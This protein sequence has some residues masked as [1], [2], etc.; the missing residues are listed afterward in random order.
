[1][2]AFANAQSFVEASTYRLD[3]DPD[4][5]SWAHDGA[6]ADAI[7]LRL[8]E[9]LRS[10]PPAE[11]DIHIA[12]VPGPDGCVVSVRSAQGETT[13]LP[14]EAEPSEASLI[15]AS[16]RIA[17]LAL[18]ATGADPFAA[19][20]PEPEPEPE[21]A[22][23][24]QPPTEETTPPEPEPEPDPEAEQPPPVAPAAPAPQA[25]VAPNEPPTT[26]FG[27]SLTPG[28]HA[29]SAA[30]PSAV[31]SVSFNVVGRTAGVQGF[32]LGL[33][34]NLSD[35]DVSGAQI[36][37][38]GNHIRGALSGL[39]AA[40]FY[41]R[42]QRGGQGFQFG[43]LNHAGGSFSG[44]QAGFGNLAADISGAQLGF[45]N[46]ASEDVSGIQIGFVNLARS[47]TAS[48]GLLS[49]VRS[50]PVRVEVVGSTGGMV[51]VGIRHGSAIVQNM[52]LIGGAEFGG[53]QSAGTGVD[54]SSTQL[55]LTYGLGAHVPFGRW[56]VDTDL[57]FTATFG[58]H[59]R[60]ANT[61]SR[62]YSSF[63]FRTRIS[64]GVQLARRAA[65]FVG[66]SPALIVPNGLTDLGIPHAE[67]GPFNTL[68]RPVTVWPVAHLGMRF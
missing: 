11:G 17:W 46:S 54:R 36:A 30:A 45:V 22:A 31:R 16:A 41:N 1:M 58:A 7:S 26:P 68:G 66:L 15:E 44:I 56:F 42:A 50:E 57:L 49:V 37:V 60:T 20:E 34:A 27:L 61:V 67:F 25:T 6:I 19:P 9:L 29:P 64:V 51:E 39:Q 13:E 48:L 21:P 23:T 63:I 10:W 53:T 12:W 47:S 4:C 40:I 43:M 2:A 28:M 5:G 55:M 14:L 62:G 8:P 24:T 18:V 32:E 65:L 33:G 52:L 59:S 38:G 3:T 35:G